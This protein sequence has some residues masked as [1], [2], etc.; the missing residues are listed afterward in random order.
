MLFIRHSLT[1]ILTEVQIKSVAAR[2]R[3]RWEGLIAKGY[4]KGISGVM[5]SFCIKILVVNT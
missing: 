5:K 1:G 4:L 2:G 3:I